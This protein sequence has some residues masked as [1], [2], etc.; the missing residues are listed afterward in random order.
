MEQDQICVH[1][2]IIDQSN[3]AE[4]KHCGNVRTF[5]RSPINYNSVWPVD[6]T[7]RQTRLEYISVENVDTVIVDSD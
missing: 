4:C 7:Q 1:H 6:F 3:N 5:Q 2:Y